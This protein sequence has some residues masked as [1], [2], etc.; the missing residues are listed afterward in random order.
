MM[1]SGIKNKARQKGPPASLEGQGHPLA[2]G[3]IGDARISVIQST[4]RRCVP[5]GRQAVDL[6]AFQA[7]WAIVVL[8]S[9]TPSFQEENRFLILQARAE[10]M[11]W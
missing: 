3:R 5:E 6:S 11:S 2:T 10:N 9:S 7:L 8:S 4:E 1:I